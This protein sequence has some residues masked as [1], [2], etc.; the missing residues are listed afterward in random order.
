MVVDWNKGGTHGD[1]GGSHESTALL[2]LVFSLNS[3]S[4]NLDLIS[5]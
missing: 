2:L 5:S 1:G 4:L 3:F